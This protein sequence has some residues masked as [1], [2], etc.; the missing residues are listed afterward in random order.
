MESYLM[1]SEVL[2]SPL[3]TF[4][5]RLLWVHIGGWICGVGGADR[6]YLVLQPRFFSENWSSTIA[7]MIV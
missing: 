4:C 6:L 3:Y 7:I 1:S 5:L 2:E